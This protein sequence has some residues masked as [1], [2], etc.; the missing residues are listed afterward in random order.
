M[1]PGTAEPAAAARDQPVVAPAP[2]RPTPKK[3]SP[4][5]RCTEI[6]T[7]ASLGEELSAQDQ[8]MLK[9]ECRR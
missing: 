4:N 2:A 6:I 3:N 5:P 7:R 1:A 9:G 8:A